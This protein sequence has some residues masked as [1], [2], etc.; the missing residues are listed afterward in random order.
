MSARIL[1]VDDQ[2]LNVKLLKDKLLAEYYD[3]V[4]A[5]DGPTALE[6]ASEQKPDI[7][8][9]DI[10][11]PG[12]DG[13]EV[14]RRMKADPALCHI[15]VVMVTALGD[16]NERV[17]GIEA[18]ADDFLTKPIND[19]AMLARVRSLLRMKL[20]F[21]ELR[22]R[23]HTN[24]QLLAFDEPEVAA[25]DGKNAHIL[26]VEDE[27]IDA[28]MIERILSPENDV[29]CVSDAE[30]A[31]KTRDDQPFDLIIVSLEI[32]GCDGLR[33]CTQLRSNDATRDVPLLMLV[34]HDDTER[35]AKG[36]D[37]GINDYVYRPIDRNELV[38]RARGQ[39]RHKRYREQ[40]RRVRN[41]SLSLAVTD[42]LTGLYNRR[43][44]DSHLAVQF[45]RHKDEGRSL[46][47]AMIDIDHF[48]A[49]NDTHGHAAGDE[50]LNEV[51]NVLKSNIRASDLVARHG[52]EEFV[53]VMPNTDMS[54]AE[55]V[56]GRIRHEIT[57]MAAA[58]P[59]ITVSIGLAAT[60]DNDD[61]PQ[62]LLKRADDALYEAKRSGRN[63]VIAAVG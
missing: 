53:V 35:M 60:R 6:V 61:T 23:D 3:V 34:D 39:I 7:V 55:V 56:S 16:P 52:G 11:M 2:P 32:D 50:V 8:L 48:K 46:A 27:A 51:A 17:R 62:R 30:A 13:Y 42:S 12:M 9:L 31:L 21:D 4:T 41:R 38:A 36:L 59:P 14:C 63:R 47:V 5:G 49:I 19:V 43:Y 44:L 45:E 57:N 25:D 10:M 29:T 18:G 20:V 24:L 37:L 58:L 26:V 33:V 15:P 40:L 1:V 28:A 22:L 54:A